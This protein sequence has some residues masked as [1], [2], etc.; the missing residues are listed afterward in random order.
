MLKLLEKIL[1]FTMNELNYT[2]GNL[3]K[4]WLKPRN[5]ML[6]L[7]S[8]PKLVEKLGIAKVD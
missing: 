2:V 8:L 7:L 3:P 6:K 1:D 5:R 4:T